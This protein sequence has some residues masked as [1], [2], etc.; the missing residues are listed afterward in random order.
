MGIWDKIRS[1]FSLRKLPGHALWVLG[2]GWRL[3]D[4]GGRLDVFSRMV[5]GMGGTPA[6]LADVLLFTL[7]KLRTDRGRCWL[8]HLC[9]RTGERRS[10]TRFLALHRLGDICCVL[11]FNDWNSWLWGFGI[12]PPSCL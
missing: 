5:E 9:W 4:Y 10:K 8:C 11:Y 2:I 7:D 12:Y 3:L 6:M 1:A